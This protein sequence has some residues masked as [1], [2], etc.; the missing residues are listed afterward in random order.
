VSL[1]ATPDVPD[2]IA[3]F[4]YANSRFERQFAGKPSSRWPRIKLALDLIS[5]GAAGSL[6]DKP[7][8][9]GARFDL[10]YLDSMD[11]GSQVLRGRWHT[12]RAQRHR[13]AEARIATALFSDTTPFKVLL[14]DD[15]D[16]PWGGKCRPR[17]DYL[18]TERWT[19][20][21]DGAQSLWIQRNERF[22]GC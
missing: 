6:R 19:C 7:P 22:Q 16:R 10:S 12:W 18:R 8:P 2:P 9:S 1:K 20:L 5:Q 21:Y 11:A 14:L 17:K 3:E 4:M 15:N 13:L